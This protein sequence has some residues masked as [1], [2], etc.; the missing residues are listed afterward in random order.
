[1]TL[2]ARCLR[3]G[4]LV[5]GATLWLRIYALETCLATTI[6]PFL[7][8]ELVLDA[9]FVGIAECETAGGIV[10]NYAVAESW[11][12]AAVGTKLSIRVAVDYWEP[13][14][15]VA[16]CDERYLVTAF[17]SATFPNVTS[18]TVGGAVP[19]W[20]RKAL[21]DYELPLFQGGVLL[22]LGKGERPLGGVGSD[23]TDLHSF[24][25]AVSDFL[26]LRPSERELHLLRR[27]ADKYL[28]LAPEQTGQL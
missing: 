7:W 10:A 4:A 26:K 5:C 2:A 13:Q 27:F 14:F 6:D 22:P 11:K 20:W 24:K 1:M 9:D 17:K 21:A 18:M 16:L 8:E 28:F 23:H 12:G 19:L 25:Q 3:V 15:P